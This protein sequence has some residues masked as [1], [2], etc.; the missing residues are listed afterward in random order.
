MPRIHRISQPGCDLTTD[1]D[2]VRAIDAV[3]RGGET[4]RK[5]R[6]MH[7][8]PA[9]GTIEEGHYLTGPGSRCVASDAKVGRPTAMSGP[10]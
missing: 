3:L 10:P 4:G 9:S 6:E 2:S 1:V 7:N 8:R 5:A